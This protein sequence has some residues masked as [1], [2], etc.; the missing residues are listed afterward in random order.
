MKS[1][2]YVQEVSNLS[3]LSNSSE[4]YFVGLQERDIFYIPTNNFI[5]SDQ[6]I[7]AYGDRL[8]Q[9]IPNRFITESVYARLQSLLSAG[10][11]PSFIRLCGKFTYT[12]LFPTAPGEVPSPQPYRMILTLSRPMEI[13]RAGE[14]SGLV[15]PF[16]WFQR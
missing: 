10:K 8:L 4:A 14:G 5:L 7:P 9:G 3:G 12:F 16:E 6:I 13:V 1:W 15:L 11:S 2:T